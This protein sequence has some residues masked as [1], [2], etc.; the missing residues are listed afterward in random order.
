MPQQRL[1]SNRLNLGVCFASSV[2]RQQYMSSSLLSRT[3]C[4][5]V[6]GLELSRTLSAQRSFLECY[7]GSKAFRC[8]KNGTLVSLARWSLY[9]SPFGYTISWF[10]PIKWNTQWPMIWLMNS[11]KDATL[12]TSAWP[13]IGGPF[14]SLLAWLSWHMQLCWHGLVGYLVSW[15]EIAKRSYRYEQRK[16]YDF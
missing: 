4:L 7:Y 13:S 16:L 1:R 14:G 10:W 11:L 6:C 5:K 15:K 2:R 8:Q 9:S 12:P 3:F